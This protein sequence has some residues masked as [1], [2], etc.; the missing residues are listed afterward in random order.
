M[1]WLKCEYLQERL[2]DQLSGVITAVTR[3]GVFVELDDLF[4]E[5]LVHIN[6]LGQDYFHYDQAQQRLIGERTQAAYHLGDYL[7]VIVARVDL[8]ERKVDLELANSKA[9]RRDRLMK[10]SKKSA[11]KKSTANKRS[12][13]KKTSAKANTKKTT[14]GRAAKR[15]S[16]SNARSATEQ[17]VKTQAKGKGKGKAKATSNKKTKRKSKKKA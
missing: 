9:P 15:N 12:K 1:A 11:S 3:F 4:V 5:G 14:G 10:K 17:P 8:D 16:A 13:S 2:G 7:Q 6:S